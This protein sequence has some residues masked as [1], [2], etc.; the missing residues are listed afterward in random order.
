MF[1]KRKEIGKAEA[2]MMVVCACQRV[3]NE[4]ASQACGLPASKWLAIQKIS[5]M[6]VNLKIVM[7]FSRHS[8]NCP[9]RREYVAI[10]VKGVRKCQVYKG[11]W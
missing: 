2:G 10:P 4:R 9:E 11:D 7:R 3:G 1:L 6:H 8:N 5:Q